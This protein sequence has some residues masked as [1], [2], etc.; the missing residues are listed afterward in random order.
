MTE[1]SYRI[2]FTTIFVFVFDRCVNEGANDLFVLE[3][4]VLRIPFPQVRF[5]R[6]TSSLY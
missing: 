3:F 1:L 2:V 5:A 4:T 6:Q